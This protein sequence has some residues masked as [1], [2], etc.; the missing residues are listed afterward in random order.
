MHVMK[1]EDNAIR[2][3]ALLAARVALGASIAANGAQKLF[4]WF[5]GA[6]PDATGKVFDS[7]GFKP[8]RTYAT[9][10]SA[11]EMAAGALI[12]LGAGG[13]L[14]AAM[15]ASVMTTAAGSVHAKNGYFASKQGFE[16]N[17][18]YTIAALLIAMDDNGRYSVDEAIGLRNMNVPPLV[19]VA[20]FTGGIAAGIAMLARRQLTQPHQRSSSNGTPQRESVPA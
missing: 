18:M 10:A 4:G 8:G 14:G 3:A 16:L 17:T 12:A 20:V 9:L 7:L 15:L 19:N 13:P 5:G 1:R 6:G 2:D 11:T